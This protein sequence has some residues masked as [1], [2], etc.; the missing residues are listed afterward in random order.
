MQNLAGWHTRV[1]GNWNAI[2]EYPSTRTRSTGK[3]PVVAMIYI[4]AGISSLSF[5]LWA[6]PPWL[7]V[8]ILMVAVS[9]AIWTR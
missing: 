9:W 6:F 8:I 2:V 1:L 7:T 5:L 4:V 3:G